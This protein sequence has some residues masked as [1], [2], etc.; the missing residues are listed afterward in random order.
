M[1]KRQ[2]TNLRK[3]AQSQLVCAG[4]PDGRGSVRA[5]GEPSASGAPRALSQ[6]VRI[7]LLRPPRCQRGAIPNGGGRN[8]LRPNLDS[9]SARRWHG[10]IR[11]TPLSATDVPAFTRGLGMRSH[12]RTGILRGRRCVTVLS[13]LG[14]PPH[15]VC[16]RGHISPSLRPPN[17]AWLPASGGRRLR[18]RPSVFSGL[19]PEMAP[20]T[21]RWC[22]PIP[23]LPE[24]E[25]TPR[26]RGWRATS[27]LLPGVPLFSFADARCRA[28]VPQPAPAGLL[29]KCLQWLSFCVVMMVMLE[30]HTHGVGRSTSTC[31]Q[32]R[33]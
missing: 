26:F 25:S 29:K 6:Q 19:G 15:L 1:V 5:G 9:Y 4:L 8:A 12:L 23:L 33:T 27:F 7:L 32:E 13:G 31:A 28:S 24:S 3:G 14:N 21:Q 17:Q 16:R 2:V 20:L 10:A 30:R 22:N 11:C 18:T